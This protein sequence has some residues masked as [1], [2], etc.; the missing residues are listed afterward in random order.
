MNVEELWARAQTA[1]SDAGIPVF[2]GLPGRDGAAQLEL[3]VWP[4]EEDPDGFI[5]F[6]QRVGPRVVYA[7]AD[8]LGADDLDEF[9]RRVGPVRGAADQLAEARS[10]FGQLWRA[11]V[12]FVCD[13]VF[14]VWEVVAPWY[15]ELDAATA[16]LEDS[17]R[18]A[19][20]ESWQRQLI[21]LAAVLAHDPMFATA[22]NDTDRRAV[23][24][25]LRPESELWPGNVRSDVV[26]RAKRI[27]TADVLPR[28]ER[29]LAEQAREL[30]DSGMARRQAARTLDIGDDRLARLLARYPSDES[31]RSAR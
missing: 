1:L 15:L 11:A 29:D 2:P 6:L 5:T 16:E 8:H 23:L 31:R 13:G 20:A 19:E 24:A 18:L 3:V 25:D 12:G 28:L 9:G 27:F 26:S 17:Q 22:R 30:I 21:D 4:D 7:A 10:R 14:H